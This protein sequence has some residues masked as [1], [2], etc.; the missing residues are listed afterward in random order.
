MYPQPDNTTVIFIEPLSKKGFERVRKSSY[1][2]FRS[3]MHN[4][5]R[6]DSHVAIQLGHIPLTV[7]CASTSHA[8]MEALTNATLSKFKKKNET[9][10]IIHSKKKYPATFAG[11]AVQKPF[12]LI[13]NAHCC[14]PRLCQHSKVIWF[15]T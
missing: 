11:P 4:T 13:N 7:I 1:Q 5:L 3:D 14:V 8:D 12:V 9:T 10:Q 15:E 2:V 6:D